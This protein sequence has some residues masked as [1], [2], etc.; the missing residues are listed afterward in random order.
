MKNSSVVDKRTISEPWLANLRTVQLT[1]MMVTMTVQ[2]I[3]EME[4][5]SGKIIS[6]SP[7]HYFVY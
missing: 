5:L 6:T 7:S 3:I 1:N 2:P 4:R